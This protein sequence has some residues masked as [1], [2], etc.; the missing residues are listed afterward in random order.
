M[1]G[2]LNNGVNFLLLKEFYRIANTVHMSLAGWSARQV[3]TYMTF[4]VQIIVVTCIG[5][6]NNKNSAKCEL[7]SQ[8]EGSVS[9]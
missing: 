8:T 5:S 2:C 9:S 3:K 1:L 7:N 4:L 6:L